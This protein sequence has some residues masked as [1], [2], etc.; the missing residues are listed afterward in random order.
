MSTRS[1]AAAFSCGLLL[2]LLLL[3]L[4][5]GLLWR[6]LHCWQGCS[7]VELAL[8]SIRISKSEYAA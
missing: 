4:L 3:L 8:H 5:A 1:R 7:G 2:L 6:R